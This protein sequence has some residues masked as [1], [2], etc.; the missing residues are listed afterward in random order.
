[1]KWITHEKH[2]E[3]MHR[4]YSADHVLILKEIDQGFEIDMEDAK[5]AVLHQSL[6]RKGLLFE[7]ENKLTTIG[8]E[9]LVFVD[10]KDRKKI[11]KPK[12][13]STEFDEFWEA[14]KFGTLE[15][16]R[17]ECIQIAAMAIRFLMDVK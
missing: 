11:N 5:V 6:V 2:K 17:I 10:S 7:T 1:M 3:L 13:S 12:A 15:E 8:R 16:Q 4:G 14:I 9:L